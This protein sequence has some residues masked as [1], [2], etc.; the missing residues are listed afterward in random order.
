MSVAASGS[1]IGLTTGE[2]TLINR[3]MGG[4]IVPGDYR[5]F[6]GPATGGSG[7]DPSRFNF[8]DFTGKYV[9]HCHNVVH[10]DHAMMIRFDIEP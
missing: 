3:S 9:M 10:E 7:T 1:V 8:R 5:Q 2:R 6:D 4:S